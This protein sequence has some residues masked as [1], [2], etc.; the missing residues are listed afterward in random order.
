MVP[1]QADGVELVVVLVLAAAGVAG[2]LGVELR[3]EGL[4][5]LHVRVVVLDGQVEGPP[6][7]LGHQGQRRAHDAARRAAAAPRAQ[8]RPHVHVVAWNKPKRSFD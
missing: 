2:R 8:P 6:V 7:L 3:V 1:V 4:V 5:R